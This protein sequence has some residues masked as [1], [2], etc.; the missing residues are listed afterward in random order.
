[1]FCKSI[2]F[3]PAE[4]NTSVLVK[5]AKTFSNNIHSF[6]SSLF[7]KLLTTQILIY[8][9]SFSD[10]VFVDFPDQLSHLE[11]MLMRL[12]TDLLK[13]SF[14]INATNPVKAQLFRDSTDRLINPKSSSLL[15]LHSGEEGQGSFAGWGVETSH[16]QP[17]PERG[18]AV[19]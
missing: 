15:F 16:E 4:W 8:W 18:V 2:S 1:M 5:M 17:A 7:N 6:F 3:P 14:L 10:N 19:G 9:F 13:V 11:A 12:S